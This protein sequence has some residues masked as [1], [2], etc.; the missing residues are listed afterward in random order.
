MH[1][2]TV[3][4]SVS[5]DPLAIDRL[6]DSG[7]QDDVAFDGDRPL[8][9]EADAA[10]YLHADLL[11]PELG[12]ELDESFEDLVPEIKETKLGRGKKPRVITGPVSIYERLRDF[13]L[14]RKM[15]DITLAEVSIPWHL[16]ADAAQ[17]IHT[18]WAT[19]Q[20]KPEFERNQVAYYAYKSGQHAALKLRRLIGA[21]VT[22]PG[23]VF[24]QKT[25]LDGEPI[26]PVRKGKESTFLETIGAAVNPKDVD[27]F[28]DSMELALA[29]PDYRMSFKP[30][31]PDYLQRRLEELKL[32]TSQRL[33]AEYVLIRKMS[34]DGVAAELKVKP[35][36]VERLLV[37][38]AQALE[39]Y[40]S[41]CERE[42]IEMTPYESTKPL[43]KNEHVSE[44]ACWVY[45]GGCGVVNLRGLPEA[46]SSA[47]VLVEAG[48]GKSQLGAINKLLKP[49]LT[50]SFTPALLGAKAAEL[51]VNPDV[52]IEASAI[53]VLGIDFS[54]LREP[55]VSV[56]A[57]F[58][59]PTY[60]LLT[61]EFQQS[62]QSKSGCLLSAGFTVSWNLNKA[63]GV[64]SLVSECARGAE[65]LSQKREAP[66]APATT[67]KPTRKFLMQDV[68]W[69]N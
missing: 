25:G 22:I 44:L 11:E 7:Y 30:V 42:G 28:K 16:R 3:D 66:V 20:A 19:L 32:N 37:Q 64:K 56:K 10:Y 6:I 2:T 36:Y 62:W 9:A 34:V 26:L 17:E 33:A 41:E 24:R 51:F 60:A 65:G 43:P 49:Y 69:L 31:T 8:E 67:V 52:S 5:G 12:L 27:D 39:A 54:N 47:K 40:D 53:E 35:E 58:T 59:V 13:G 61:P 38:V 4:T 55:L 15:T 14:L 50:C 23:A 48:Q 18:A 63:N 29:P 57:T 46:L 45:R 68:P 21:A 1:L